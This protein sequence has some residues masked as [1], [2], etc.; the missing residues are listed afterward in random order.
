MNTLSEV[1]NCLKVDA[2]PASG[3]QTVVVEAA[4]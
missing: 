3:A 2:L 1:E 4:F